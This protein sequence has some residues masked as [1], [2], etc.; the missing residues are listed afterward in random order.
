MSDLDP[1][2]PKFC[3]CQQVAFGEMIGCDNDEVSDVY[4][5]V[6]QYFLCLI[7]SAQTFSIAP[8]LIQ[9]PALV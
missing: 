1:N 9:H 3:L 5:T 6:L 4:V 2:E 7:A 8:T